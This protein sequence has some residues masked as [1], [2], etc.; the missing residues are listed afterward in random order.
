LD[1]PSLSVRL[2]P[3]GIQAKSRPTEHLYRYNYLSSSKP[4]SRH[5]RDPHEVQASFRVFKG[6][7]RIPLAQ[8]RPICRSATF[9]FP[10]FLCCLSIRKNSS[11]YRLTRPFRVLAD[12]LTALPLNSSANLQASLPGIPRELSLLFSA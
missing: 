1:P 4:D 11:S 8:I 3:S 12:S 6:D 5:S 10:V 2:R 7:C 9:R